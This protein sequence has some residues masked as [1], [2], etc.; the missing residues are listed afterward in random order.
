MGASVIGGGAALG[1]SLGGGA[2]VVEPMTGTPPT[3]PITEEMVGRLISA[4]MTLLVFEVDRTSVITGSR[5][6]G[7]GSSGLSSKLELGSV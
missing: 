5:S 7:S 1:K 3:L 2:G 6:I 4:L